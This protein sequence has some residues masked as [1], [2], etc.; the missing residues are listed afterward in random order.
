LA[1]KID[2]GS[3]RIP[4]EYVLHQMRHLGIMDITAS[5]PRYPAICGYFANLYALP[6]TPAR[7]L[8]Y[9]AFSEKVRRLW[10]QGL[11]TVPFG[12]F[13]FGDFDRLS[14]A[15]LDFG[16]SRGTPLDRYYLNKFVAESRDLV[17]GSVLEI[18]GQKGSHELYGFK[19][20]TSYV[21]M[22]IDS[23]DADITTDAHD[24]SAALPE[25]YDSIIIFNVLEHC[26]RPWVIASNIYSWLKPG[27][28]VFV[29][30]PNM[31]R[32]HEGPGDYWR[33][34]PEGL[35]SIF[36]QF[37]VEKLVTYG[38][39]FTS[40]AAL[41]GV[42]SEEIPTGDKD[43]LDTDYP[44]ITCMTGSKAQSSAKSKDTRI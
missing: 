33:I 17:V 34:L 13:D 6:V 23:S 32:I 15:C 8:P 10:N 38:N 40:I 28:R 31:Q 22:S 37:N 4:V 11:L 16:F 20:A 29:M 12:Q 9:S 26:R 25:S 2:Y 19:N 44:T 5:L 39:L 41:S 14:P 1:N 36:N 27:G 42:S 35:R 43:S 24:A 7:P 21:T 3:C 30:I 18:G